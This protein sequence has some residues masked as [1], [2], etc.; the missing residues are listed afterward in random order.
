MIAINAVLLPSPQL[1]N[2]A[3]DLSNRIKNTSPFTLNMKDRLPHISLVMGYVEDTESAVDAV[4][5]ISKQ[6]GPVELRVAGIHRYE[7]SFAGKYFFEIQF[8]Q[9][10]QI[11]SIQNK[12]FKTLPLLEVENPSQKAF[13]SDGEEIINSAVLDYVGNFKKYSGDEK[14]SPH[15]TLGAAEKDAS[16]DDV[17]LP[18][19]ITISQITLCHLGNYCTCRKI[20][21]Y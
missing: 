6:I 5:L 12:L 14:F 18:S 16:F 20:I 10:E 2:I 21:S 4:Q 1:S 7:P 9:N 3:I 15:I 19:T 17:K 8:E 13:V 11:L